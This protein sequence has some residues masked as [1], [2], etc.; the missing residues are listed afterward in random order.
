MIALAASNPR[1]KLGFYSCGKQGLFPGFII[2]LQI[3]YRYSQYLSIKSMEPSVVKILAG[4]ISG[5]QRSS[6]ETRFKLKA[7]F[8]R[9][10]KP[11]AFKLGSSLRPNERPSSTAAHS[12]VRCVIRPTR[13]ALRAHLPPSTKPRRCSKTSSCRER[14]ASAWPQCAAQ[15]GG[16]GST[17]RDLPLPLPP[18]AARFARP[19]RARPP[20]C[21]CTTMT[22]A[23]MVDQ[24]TTSTHERISV[25][26]S[27]EETRK[28]IA[29]MRT[30]HQ[31]ETTAAA[32]TKT[33][34]ETKAFEAANFGSGVGAKVRR[35]KLDQLE[36]APGFKASTL[37]ERE[38]CFQ[39]ETWFPELAPLHQGRARGHAHR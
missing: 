34:V 3:K 31:I 19:V 8:Y 13:D 33:F 29:Q 1:Y 35:C 7:I 21:C 26:A 18:I 6:P 2:R 28:M 15:R 39:F 10:M 30:L 5:F 27:V 25:E 38:H 22:Q 4:V 37:M 14:A 11:G 9:I 16:H 12:T 20:A 24:D 23:G 36:S 32:E 17:R